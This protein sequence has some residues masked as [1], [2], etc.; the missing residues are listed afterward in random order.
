MKDQ[1]VK[2]EDGEGR[3][4][5][6][7]GGRVKEEEMEEE[8]E[9][10][11]EEMEEEVKEEEMEEEVKEE[12]EKG[13]LLRV[14]SVL[15]LQGSG[16]FLPAIAHWPSL[17]TSQISSEACYGSSDHSFTDGIIHSRHG[18]SSQNGSQFQRHGTCCSG[19]L[20]LPPLASSQ[21]AECTCSLSV[22]QEL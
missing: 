11:E 13:Y 4:G 21:E 22:P 12:E 10:K 16:H 14:W 17:A 9:V 2:E 15:H 19:L 3:R 1:E 5:G 7:G 18:P 8:E 20:P 6:K